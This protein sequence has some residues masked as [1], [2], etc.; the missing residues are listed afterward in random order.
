MA[1]DLVGQRRLKANEPLV[2]ALSNSDTAVRHAALGALGET[3]DASDLKL[4]IAR[5]SDAQHPE[6]QPVA[7]QALRSA[8]IR[9]EDREAVAKQLS[10]S[11]ATQPTTVKVKL[12]EILAEVGG[13][14]SLLA[15]KAAF[16]GSD[17]T[18]RDTSSRLLGNWATVEAGP[19]LLELA[20][21]PP[22]VYTTRAMRGYIRLVRQFQM[23]DEQRV[24]MCRNAMKAAKFEPEQ[25][26]VVEV[27]ERYPSV[28]MMDAAMSAQPLPKIKDLTYRAALMIAAKMPDNDEIK[29]RLNK[30][31][32][33][34]VKV[35]I[36]K[37]EY[38]TA[39]TKRDAT[40]ALRK[41][42]KEFPVIPLTA[43]YDKTFGGSPA[44]KET[45]NVQYRVN[46]KEGT[47][48]FAEDDSIYLK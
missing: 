3:I 45:L 6:D 32:F 38:G 12:L 2:K 27:M 22:S 24:E 35:E 18:L 44:T 46:G 9:M 19:T 16:T 29:S 15:M 28:A 11:M 48:T 31:G 43:S 36:V 34:P 20:Q 33:K 4:L 14:N 26:L 13:Q 10:A 17:N 1:I 8:S 25:E 39:E 42:V 41:L 5:L 47:A 40:E 7:Q 21:L 30:L 37:A 23:P